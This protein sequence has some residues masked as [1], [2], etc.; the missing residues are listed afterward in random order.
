M[1]DPL[2]EHDKKAELPESNPVAPSG[3]TDE[4]AADLAEE[5]NAPPEA[6]GESPAN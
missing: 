4:L 5:W 2:V 3:K 1:T 6:A